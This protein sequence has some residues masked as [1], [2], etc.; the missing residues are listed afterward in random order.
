ME[1]RNSEDE[2]STFGTDESLAAE[3][4]AE[5]ANSRYNRVQCRNST[6][7]LL[8]HSSFLTNSVAVGQSPKQKPKG[9]Q[10][11]STKGLGFYIKKYGREDNALTNNLPF[12][13][14][15]FE[16]YYRFLDA[17]YQ[18]E[19]LLLTLRTF[20]EAVFYFLTPLLFL[21]KKFIV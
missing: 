14:I 20:I 8:L 9:P 2:I 19:V 16:I 3:F 6:F 5:E 1:K 12:Q 17:V 18:K 21:G 10:K 11:K 13:P 15:W 4:D 7:R